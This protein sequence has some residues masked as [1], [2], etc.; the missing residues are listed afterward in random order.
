AIFTGAA[1]LLPAVR[2][3]IGAVAPG[4]NLEPA[5]RVAFLVETVRLVTCCLIVEDGALPGDFRPSIAIEIRHGRAD[6]LVALLSKVLQRIGACGRAPI[7]PR[8]YAE[9]DHQSGQ[10]LSHQKPPVHLLRGATARLVLA[11]YAD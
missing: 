6:R 9:S 8:Q 2:N 11:P 1:V 7:K 4:Q 3:D 5:P 10:Q